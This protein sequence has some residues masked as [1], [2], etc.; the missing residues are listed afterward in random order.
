[1]NG[2]GAFNVL[3]HDSMANHGMKLEAKVSANA[4]SVKL[5]SKTSKSTTTLHPASTT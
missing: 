5:V 2:E 3:G 1:M 4:T